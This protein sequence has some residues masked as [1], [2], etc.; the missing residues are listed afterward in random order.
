VLIGKISR[1]GG[2]YGQKLTIDIPRDVQEP[3]PGTF[4]ALS[5]IETTLR[6]TDGQRVQ[7]ARD[8]RV[9]R[10]RRPEAQLPVQADVRP[11]PHASGGH[12]LD[13]DGHGGLH[14]VAPFRPLD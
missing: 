11:Q 12:D 2:S 14:E 13:R 5:D 8:L 7:A 10:L 6:G 4:S 3:V 1:A 9:P